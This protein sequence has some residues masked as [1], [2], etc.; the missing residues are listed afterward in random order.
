MERTSWECPRC[1]RMNAP[2]LDYCSCPPRI[3]AGT[4]FGV[5]E[6]MGISCITPSGTSFCTKNIVIGSFALGSNITSEPS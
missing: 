6:P 2:H 3:T 5:Y 4:R 1:Q